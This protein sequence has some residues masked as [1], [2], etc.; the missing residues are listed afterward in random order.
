MKLQI[1]ITCLATVFSI[2]DA[3]A[4][5]IF[6]GLA[7]PG[8]LNSISIQG[9]AKDKGITLSGRDA[10]GQLIVT[11]HYSTGQQRDMTGRAT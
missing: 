10:R 5:P 11:G 8:T 6:P 9:D 3:A 7:D 2:A 1:H 4:P